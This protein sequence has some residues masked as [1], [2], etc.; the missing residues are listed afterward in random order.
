MAKPKV[1][2]WRPMYDQIGHALFEEGGVE[3]VVVDSTDAQAVMAE[4]P[5]AKAIWVRTPERITADMMDAAPEL[6][7]ISTS[8]FGTDN[9]D[10]PAATERGILVVNNLGFGR[11]PVSEHTIM[12]LLAVMNRLTW[13]D[14]ATRDGSGWDAR[15]N[16]SFR[17]LEGSTIGIVGLGYIGSELARKLVSGFRCRVLGYDPYIN[18]RI[19]PTAGVQMVEHLDDLL[20]QV[21]VLC[22]CAEL[23]EETQEMIS[24]RELALLAKDAVVVNTARG[25]ILDLDALADA[26]DAGH[27]FGAGIDT[28]YPEPLPDTHPIFAQDNVIFTPHTAGLT[29]ETATEQTRFSVSQILSVL[30]GDPP[31]FP[32]NPEAWKS[33]RSRKPS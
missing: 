19:P 1:V 30:K 4:L 21:S 18:P 10:I 15:T 29:S 31:T 5:D 20:R 27:I 16:V 11:K 3:L 2:V 12:L 6:I 28:T 32:V 25:R 8:G 17:E 24:R 33:G 13:G 26:L 14:R 7:V 9:V 22:L 23:T